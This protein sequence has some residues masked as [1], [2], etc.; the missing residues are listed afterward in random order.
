[1]LKVRHC[2][3][4]YYD[5]LVS[6]NQ[7][8]EPT[9]YSYVWNKVNLGIAGFAIHNNIQ[10]D[11]LTIG[12]EEALAEARNLEKILLINSGLD[13]GYIGAGFLLK[14]LA[15]DSEKRKYLLTGYGNSLILQGSFLLVFDLILYGVLHAQRMDFMEGISLSMGENYLGL[16]W[17]YRF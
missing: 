17:R 6:K 14:H 1:M 3:Y 8:C 15:S 2:Y 12:S 10:V 9:K 13:V 16:V 11:P 4:I 7:W 5:S